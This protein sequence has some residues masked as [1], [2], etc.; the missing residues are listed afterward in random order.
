MDAS[1]PPRI[2]LGVKKGAPK[3]WN[4]TEVG[5]QLVSVEVAAVRAVVA[6]GAWPP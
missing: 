4:R 3:G 5:V 1:T 2:V 6:L